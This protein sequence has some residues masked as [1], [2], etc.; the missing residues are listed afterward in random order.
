[1]RYRI[2]YNDGKPCR[3]EQNRTDLVRYLKKTED[4]SIN[5]IRRVFKDN[6][7]DSAFDIYSVYLKD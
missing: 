7:T 4:K 1:M 5:D 6:R 3:Y 2:E